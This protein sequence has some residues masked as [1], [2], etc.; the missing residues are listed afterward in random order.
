M[1]EHVIMIYLNKR[2]TI[3]NQNILYAADVWRLELLKRLWLKTEP[4]SVKRSP[5]PFAQEIDLS[6]KIKDDCVYDAQIQKLERVKQYGRYIWSV[7]RIEIFVR[8]T[9]LLCNTSE[10]PS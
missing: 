8:A 10:Q 2:E 4:R 7:L 5:M 3:M 9:L 6:K 1:C